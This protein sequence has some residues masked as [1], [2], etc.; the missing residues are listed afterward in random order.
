VTLGRIGTEVLVLAIGALLE[1]EID[2][3]YRG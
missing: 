3:G 1:R 2:F